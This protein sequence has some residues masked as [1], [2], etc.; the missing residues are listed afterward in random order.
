MTHVDEDALQQILDGEIDP[1]AGI[2]FLRHIA[3]CQ[4]CQEVFLAYGS[5]FSALTPA[6]S[7]HPKAASWML[8]PEGLDDETSGRLLEVEKNVMA[9]VS[10][11][12]PPFGFNDW[13]RFLGRTMSVIPGVGKAAKATGQMA[14]MVKRKTR[15]LPR[16][17][18][19]GGVRI[20]KL[21]ALDAGQVGEERPGRPEGRTLSGIGT[22]VKSISLRASWAG[23]RGLLGRVLPEWGK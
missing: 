2:A 1:E 21:K 10:R 4:A 16:D 9:E 8:L 18:L 6:P 11:L 17:V 3:Q 19:R 14:Q 12:N 22:F 7:R 23:T 5:I 20:F 15:S 13:V